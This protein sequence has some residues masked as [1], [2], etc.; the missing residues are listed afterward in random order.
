M[1]VQKVQCIIL[2]DGEAAPL[3]RHVLVDRQWEDNYYIGQRRIPSDRAYLRNRKTGTTLNL[4]RD[5]S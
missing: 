4:V 2:T 3:N 5:I 1:D